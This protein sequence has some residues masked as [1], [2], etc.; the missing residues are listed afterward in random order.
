M[1]S[2]LFK[3]A[4]GSLQKSLRMGGAA[5]NPRSVARERLQAMVA[6]HRN[7]AAVSGVN[8]HALQADMIQ[9]IKVRAQPRRDAR[10]AP[11]SSAA[12]SVT[13]RAPA[14]LRIFVPNSCSFFANACTAAS[15]PH[16]AFGART[17]ALSDIPNVTRVPRRA[18]AFANSDTCKCR[19]TT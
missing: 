3:E 6:V 2:R 13:C 10:R 5:E 4:V 15:P 17:D 16:L 7:A 14:L 11:H 18:P 8:F 1:V 12:L 19:T 9:C